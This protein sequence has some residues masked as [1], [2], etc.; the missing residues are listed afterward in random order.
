MDGFLGFTHDAMLIAAGHQCAIDDVAM[1]IYDGLLL[2]DV[3]CIRMSSMYPI[4]DGFAILRM[5]KR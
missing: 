3:G 4:V 5:M 2:E 1:L